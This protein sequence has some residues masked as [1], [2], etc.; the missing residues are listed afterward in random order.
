MST[1]IA[2]EIKVQLIMEG[3]IANLT[4]FNRPNLSIINPEKMLANGTTIT[5][6]EAVREKQNVS[7]K[8][9]NKGEEIKI[10]IPIQ[11]TCL[12]VA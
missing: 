10:R 9:F 3:S 2:N 4:A 6:M 1:L 5:N 11:A 12:G 8:S 7:L